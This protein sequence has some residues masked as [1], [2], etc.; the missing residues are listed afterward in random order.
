MTYFIGGN[1]NEELVQ[2]HCLAATPGSHVLQANARRA[3]LRHDPSSHSTRA[4]E[5][6]GNIIGI[7]GS[8]SDGLKASDSVI[9]R[10]CAGADPESAGFSSASVATFRLESDGWELRADFAG[11]FPIYYTAE[12]GCFLFSTQLRPLA[13]ML[14]AE[15]DAAGMAEFVRLGYTIG[16]RTRFSGIRRLLPGECLRSRADET[17]FLLSQADAFGPEATPE[18]LGAVWQELESA[19][20]RQFTGYS[21][22]GVMTSGGWD[23]RF[24]LSLLRKCAPDASLVCYSYGNSASREI[25]IATEIAKLAEAQP[26]IAGLDAGLLDVVRLREYYEAAD[27]LLF[28]HWRSAGA[29]LRALGFKVGMAGVLGEV[30]GGH[31]G[32]PFYFSGK[33]K[34]SRVY[35]SLLGFDS[36]SMA[37]SDLSQ[38][39]E[40]FLPGGRLPKPWSVDKQWWGD[41]PEIT[42][43][44]QSDLALE[45]ER[46]SGL[47]ALNSTQLIER[48]TAEHRGARYQVEQLRALG[49]QIGVGSPFL[50]TSVVK[51]LRA[52]PFEQRL[53]NR[54]AARLLASYDMR[55]ANLPLAATLLPAAMPTAV[56]EISRG[57][58][59]GAERLQDL[60]HKA[61]R[62]LIRRS[63][64]S[65]VDF[66]FVGEPPVI[67]PL[68]DELRSDVWDKKALRY[69]YLKYSALPA[70]ERPNLHP[71]FDQI[72]KN[73]TVEWD[74]RTAVAAQ[75]VD[76]AGM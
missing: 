10:I 60:L 16:S 66:S 17:G 61:N 53:Y 63:N 67:E 65:Y 11:A 48:F 1:A 22:A 2:R 15:F 5:W 37:A 43:T 21:P 14:G 59:V 42:E 20:R 46:L 45:M 68:V 50:D 33:A 38:F 70:G 62:R 27:S 32:P 30:L 71:Q 29:R 44:V 7:Y 23:S 4:V 12:R 69:H 19:T 57:L 35:R 31:Y 25:R 18:N 56:R 73:L 75:M 39:R 74:S 64:Y 76:P 55:Y 36:R 9:E 47:G 26:V 54:L 41:H 8:Y 51:F 49:T 58:R 3:F 72:L 34:A 6:Q 28:P 40:Y 24:L 52:I 13:I